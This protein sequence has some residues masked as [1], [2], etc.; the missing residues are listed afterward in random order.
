M[1]WATYR[2]PKPFSPAEYYHRHKHRAAVSIDV[3]RSRIRHEWEPEVALTTPQIKQWGQNKALVLS[4]ITKQPGICRSDLKAHCASDAGMAAALEALHRDGLIRTELREVV[5]S[6]G[7]RNIRVY[8]PT[9]QST[10]VMAETPI[11][12]E[13]LA[14][15]DRAWAPKPFVHPIRARL[16]GLPVAETE[17]TREVWAT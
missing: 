12:R 4:L 16:L 6:R 5:R 15:L 7:R 8:F 11:D 17:R 3:F 10:K 1:T 14:L 2:D 13:A 9:P